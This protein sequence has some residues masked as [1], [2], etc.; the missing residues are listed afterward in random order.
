MYL[1]YVLIPLAN[2]GLSA[3]YTLDPRY[4]LKQKPLE[5]WVIFFTVVCF[6]RNVE[7][8]SSIK[9]AVLDDARI[10]LETRKLQ[11]EGKLEELERENDIIENVQ[12]EALLERKAIIELTNDDYSYMKRQRSYGEG[13]I[14]IGTSLIL[15]EDIYS[16]GFIA[17]T[18]DGIMKKHLDIITGKVIEE[19]STEGNS[20]GETPEDDGKP[21]NRLSIEEQ[22]KEDLL[23]GDEDVV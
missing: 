12:G 3:Y 11:E 5:S 20:S 4:D 22:A 18:V 2:I 16:I 23:T 17:Q 7:F 6:A 14:R 21:V 8:F 10:F 19:E 1:N 13:E 15:S 9:K